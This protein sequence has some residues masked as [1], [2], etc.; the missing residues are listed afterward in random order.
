MEEKYEAHCEVSVATWGLWHA[1]M[2]RNKIQTDV[3]GYSWHQPNI[4][5]CNRAVDWIDKHTLSKHTGTQTD[6]PRRERL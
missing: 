5:E 6:Q 2:P 4:L 1:I 3:S